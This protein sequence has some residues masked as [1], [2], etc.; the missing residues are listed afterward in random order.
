MKNFIKQAAMAAAFVMVF[1]SGTILSAQA[2]ANDYEFQL[3]SKEL[4]AGAPVDIVVRLS[5]SQMAS[6]CPTR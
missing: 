1:A 5:T 2:G 6:P 3:V 4:K